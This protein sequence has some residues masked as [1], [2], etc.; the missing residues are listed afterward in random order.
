PAP[1]LST[2]A[3]QAGLSDRLT[4]ARVLA[5]H[6]LW[7]GYMA[8]L[9]GLQAPSAAARHR[10]TAVTTQRL[11]R[12]DFHGAHMTV[13]RSRCPNYVGVAGVMVMESHATFQIVGTDDRV[14]RVPKAGAVFSVQ[15]APG[16][17]Y[18]LYGDGFI[19]RTVERSVK[20]FRSGT[21]D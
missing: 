14:R 21:I 18:E 16:A 17:F 20:K 12:A 6:Q 2:A 8:E 1:A 3:R 19:A 15:V 9:L 7:Q 5:L 11:L 10:V 13:T 4:Y